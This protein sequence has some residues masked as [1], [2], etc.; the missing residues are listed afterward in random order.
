MVEIARIEPV[1][2]SRS[3]AIKQ[4]F[5]TAMDIIQGGVGPEYAEDKDF[6]WTR[7]HAQHVFETAPGRMTPTQKEF[8]VVSPDGT[9]RYRPALFAAMGTDGRPKAG[10]Y[11][12][13]LNANGEPFMFMGYYAW[14]RG[15]RDTDESL[16]RTMF[17]TLL[18]HL[19]QASVEINGKPLSY[20]FMEIERHKQADKPLARRAMEYGAYPLAVKEDQKGFGYVQP[21]IDAE[22]HARARFSPERLQAF[23]GVHGRPLTPEQARNVDYDPALI[24][25]VFDAIFAQ[26]YLEYSER[27]GVGSRAASFAYQK[28]MQSLKGLIRVGYDL[29]DRGTGWINVPR[30]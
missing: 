27:L 21:G 5:D 20:I 16:S 13:L 15:V 23:F 26:E 2:W 12:A 19:D 6:L 17:E 18:T 4:L 30:K 10:I 7:L 8:M 28:S 25:T 9:S 29:S 3:P 14:Q 22:K 1:R 11:G 24:A